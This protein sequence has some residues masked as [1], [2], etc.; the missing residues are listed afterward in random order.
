MCYVLMILFVL[1]LINAILKIEMVVF[2][3][4]Y[5]YKNKAIINC[6]SIVYIHFCIYLPKPSRLVT[7]VVFF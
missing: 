5:K 2:H 4:A 6:D 1:I 3:N 7:T